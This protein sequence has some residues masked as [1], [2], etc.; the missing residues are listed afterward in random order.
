[1]PPGDEDTNIVNLPEDCLGLILDHLDPVTVGQLQRTSRHMYNLI[2]T[3]QYWRRAIKKLVSKHPYLEELV[4]FDLELLQEKFYKSKFKELTRSLNRCWKKSDKFKP[5]TIRNNQ[6]FC[7]R[8]ERQKVVSIKV[9]G[10]CFITVLG[11]RTRSDLAVYCIKVFDRRT[12]RKINEISNLIDKPEYLVFSPKYNIL[13]AKAHETCPSMPDTLNIWSLES[14]LDS[15]LRAYHLKSSG[16]GARCTS[17]VLKED[18][19]FGSL[20]KDCVVMVPTRYNNKS[21]VRFLALSRVNFCPETFQGGVWRTD[22]AGERF[23]KTN[24]GLIYEG[25]KVAVEE[26]GRVHIGHLVQLGVADFSDKWAI[27]FTEAPKELPDRNINLIVIDMSTM[28]IKHV[29]KVR[30]FCDA[31]T[32][33][34]SLLHAG[35]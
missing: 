19:Y 17:L 29:I 3:H 27:L 24:N 34:I 9:T 32:R 12:K 15:F 14:Q 31:V 4:D 25:Y 21:V 5:L 22:N 33:L 35:L 28:G 8:D 13:V 1:M 30:V 11:P 10:S 6:Y 20:R 2:E 16:L 7:E 18:V 26:V 23:V